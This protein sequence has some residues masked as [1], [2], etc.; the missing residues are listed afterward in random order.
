LLNKEIS[1]IA[2]SSGLCREHQCQENF[3]LHYFGADGENGEERTWM[4]MCEIKNRS[5]SVVQL[6]KVVRD[7]KHLY[8]SKEIVFLPWWRVNAVLKAHR[9]DVQ[10]F[11]VVVDHDEK[12]WI[13]LLRQVLNRVSCLK[14]LKLQ[15]C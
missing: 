12:Y 1:C 15:D 2:A 9:T 8:K 11:L 7:T 6:L 3:L 5:T 14:I 10:S 4:I 13:A